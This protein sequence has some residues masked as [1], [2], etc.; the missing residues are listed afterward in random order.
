MIHKK[1][2]LKRGG[3]SSGGEKTNEVPRYS[4]LSREV[5]SGRGGLSRGELQFSI[6]KVLLLHPS[7]IDF[8]VLK[9]GSQNERVSQPIR[10]NVTPKP[11][12]AV[13]N[14]IG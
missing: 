10:S 13:I 1:W 12:G 6:Q 3:L 7:F 4:D 8:N 9:T 11:D 2:S 5:V 14:L